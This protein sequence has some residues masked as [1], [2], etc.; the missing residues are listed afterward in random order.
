MADKADFHS[1]EQRKVIE[2]TGRRLVIVAGPGTGKTSTIVARMIRLLEE[3]PERVVS[4]LTF[5]RASSRDTESKVKEA[6]GKEPVET[7]EHRM[8][9]R[10]A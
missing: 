9:S 10:R 6:V 1:P 8:T 7:A 2:F 3:N 4:F 5:T